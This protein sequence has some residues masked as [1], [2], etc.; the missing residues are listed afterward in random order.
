MFY[1]FIIAVLL[2]VWGFGLKRT[3]TATAIGGSAVY[4]FG[5]GVNRGMEN[6]HATSETMR[7]L[8]DTP[9]N[10]ACKETVVKVENAVVDILDFTPKTQGNAAAQAAEDAAL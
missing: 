7:Y 4:A 9:V 3:I 6:A 2:L 8:Q 10:V 5:K 1:L